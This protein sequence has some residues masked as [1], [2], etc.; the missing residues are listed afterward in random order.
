MAFDIA[1]AL[2]PSPFNPVGV[3]QQLEHNRLAQ[4]ENYR[5]N[6][7]LG[8]KQQ[9]FQNALA[10][11]QQ[12]QG[13]IDA[14]ALQNAIDH[15]VRAP[16]GQAGDALRELVA[17]KPQIAQFA[18]TLNQ[19]HGVDVSTMD[20]ATARQLANTVAN[21]FGI[22]SGLPVAQPKFE[23]VAPGATIARI[24]PNA[25]PESQ[26][27]TAFSA[28]A[29]PEGPGTMYQY[30]GPDGK[31]AYGSATD[32]QGKTPYN[33]PSAADSYS[34]SSV[35]TTA[36][37]IVNGQI[38]MLTGF[39]LKTPWGQAVVG[40]VGQIAPAIAGQ[41]GSGYQGAVYG[42]RSS[43]LKD[44]TSGKSSQT[45]RSLNV[46]IAHLG[47]LGDLATA[48]HNGDA[49]LLNKVG[50]IYK[51]QTGNP[52]PTN[53]AGARSIVANEIVKAVTAS[54]GGVTDRQEAQAEVSAA[55]SPEQLSGVI[56]TWK[57][58]LGGQLGGL[59]QQYEQGTSNRDF[60]RFLS[61][62]VIA[63]LEGPDSGAAPPTA[64]GEIT[65]TGPNGQQL[66]LRNGQWVPK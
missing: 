21:H 34:P 66:A 13:Q 28:P 31:P 41:S 42:A 14:Q 62:Q 16:P 19:N 18:Q 56:Q 23:N 43:A 15:V 37:M 12:Q 46:A 25:P 60:N 55:N 45:V 44:F 17:T 1:N 4:Q 47:T 7:E 9:D 51:T 64:T 35:E 38:P 49:Q 20:D 61:P 63:Q 50:V 6:A 10:E 39:S 32:V 65:A 57:Q 8:M 54:G 48:L 58:L 24:D 3:L 29:K 36:Q 27:S 5:A 40:R 2:Q 11:K 53:F 52:A 26:V 30:I 22:T 33:K 59:K